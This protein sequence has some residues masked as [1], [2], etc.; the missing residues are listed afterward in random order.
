M[1]TDATREYDRFRRKR[2]QFSE[3]SRAPTLLVKFW[4][5]GQV[6]QQPEILF[7]R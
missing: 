2:N 3:T 5:S 1:V 4:I 7:V 6:Y